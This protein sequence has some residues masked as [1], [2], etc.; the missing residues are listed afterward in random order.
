MSDFKTLTIIPKIDSYLRYMN[1][2][3][4]LSL[5]RSTFSNSFSISSLNLRVLL[6]RYV[7]VSTNTI[8]DDLVVD[9][10][11]GSFFWSENVSSRSK[12]LG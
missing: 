2:R 11:K 12:P 10:F 4:F 6:L 7:S 8:P 1:L 5:P 3:S 9:V